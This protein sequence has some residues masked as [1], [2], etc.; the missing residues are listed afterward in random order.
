MS[1]RRISAFGNRG[2][3]GH[4]R[5]AAQCFW[6]YR[7]RRLANTSR[8]VRSLLSRRRSRARTRDRPPSPTTLREARLCATA[9]RTLDR[10]FPGS[11]GPARTLVGAGLMPTQIARS[12]GRSRSSSVS[13]CL[14]IQSSVTRWL[15]RRLLRGRA[16]SRLI[17]LIALSDAMQRMQFGQSES[18]RLVRSLS[19]RLPMQLSRRSGR[20]DSLALFSWT[21]SRV[22]FNEFASE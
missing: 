5:R 11:S 14:P 22:R 21:R 4:R 8:A 16:D 9:H 19:A 12:P 10:A 7:L 6:S 18:V 13:T 3:L 2:A 1:R 20:R 17:S 15:K